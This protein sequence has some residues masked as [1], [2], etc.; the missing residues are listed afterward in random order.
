MARRT[1]L[2]VR[3]LI[4]PEQFDLLYGPWASVMGGGCGVT[5]L[6][7]ERPFRHLCSVADERD[8]MSDGE[9]WDDVAQSILSN[10]MAPVMDD[11]DDENYDITTDLPVEPCSVCG[12]PKLRAATTG[13]GFPTS[14]HQGGGGL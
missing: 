13:P 1:R 14:L 11:E 5:R 6:L 10:H 9:F 4:T 8:A 2:V 12:P 3:D 7:A